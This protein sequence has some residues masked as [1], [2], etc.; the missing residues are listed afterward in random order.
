MTTKNRL[1]SCLIALLALP[2]A[3]S[4]AGTADFSVQLINTFD[5]PGSPL[6]TQPQKISDRSATVGV[7]IDTS[8]VTFGFVRLKSGAFVGPLIDPMDGSNITQGRGINASLEICGNY[9]DANGSSHGFFAKGNKGTNFTNYDVPG[10]S[11]TV[12]LGLN[13]AGDFCGSDIPASGVQSGFV[14]IGGNIT[15]FTIADATATLAYQINTAN[16]AVGYYIDPAGITHGYMRGSDGSILAPI[17][18]AGST[19]TIVFGNNDSGY[20]VGRYPDASGVT[21]G[22]VFLPPST[23]VTFDYPGSTF[24]SLNG[25]NA[26]GFVVGRYLDASG[27]EHGLYARLV[28]GTSSPSSGSIPQRQPAQASTVKVSPARVQAVEPAL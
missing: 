18:P 5:F 24:T 14:N 22:F 11:F 12:L 23:Y 16:E 8:G 10:S 21:H 17:D 20:I 4:F 2:A 13:N 7:A 28:T 3:E 27:I 6:S 25:I 26:S 19:G 15:E 9:T 1:V